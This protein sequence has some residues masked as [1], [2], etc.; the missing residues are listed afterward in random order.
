MSGAAFDKTTLVRPD[1]LTW[2][3][4]PHIPKASAAVL[5][6][7][8]TKADVVVMRVPVH[9]SRCGH[10]RARGWAARC[11]PTCSTCSGR[12]GGA[13]AAGRTMVVVG[14]AVAISF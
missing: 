5:F 4:N 13:A 12:L 3:D 6:G 7:D 9:H 11:R 2:K 14:G 1:Q 10:A 8:P